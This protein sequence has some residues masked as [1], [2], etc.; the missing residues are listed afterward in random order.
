MPEYSTFYEFVQAN[1]FNKNGSFKKLINLTNVTQTKSMASKLL[2]V[3]PPYPESD[4]VEEEVLTTWR[5]IHKKANAT[6]YGCGKTDLL[7]LVEHTAK[8]Q[9][10]YNVISCLN[11]REIITDGM[12][13]YTDIFLE[14]L[15]KL[16]NSLFRSLRYRLAELFEKL[17]IRFN[18]LALLINTA[19]AFSNALLTTVLTLFG[20][21]LGSDAL[22]KFVIDPQNQQILANLTTWIVQNRSILYLVVIIGSIIWGFHAWGALKK[23]EKAAPI[24]QD[25]NEDLKA[26]DKITEIKEILA[27]DQEQILA[28]FATRQRPLLLLIDDVDVID[29][30]S[31]KSLA[32]L[33]QKAE[34]LEK[35]VVITLLGYNPWNPT[36]YYADRRTIH[37][38]FELSHIRE[39]GWD[40]L[41]LPIPTLS[42]VKTWLWGYYNHQSASDLLDVL[43]EDYVE[44]SENPSLALAFFIRLDK[45]RIQ[46]T[47][48]IQDITPSEVKLAFD[49]FL[50]RDRRITREVIQAIAKHE[51]GEGSIEM[52]KYILAYKKPKIRVEHIKA[53]MLKT[54]KYKDFATYESVLLSEELNLLQKSGT[55]PMYTFCQ[56]YMRSFLCTSWKHWRKNASRYYN[57][58]FLSI[59]R[60]FRRNRDDP[61]LALEAEPSRLAVDVLRRQGDYYFK[62]YGSSDAGYALRYYGLTRGG[63]LGKWLSLCTDALEN[64]DNL[65]EL[66]YWKGDARGLNP[67]RHWSHEADNPL[68]F[69][70]DIV[71]TAGKLYWLNGDWKTAEIIWKERWPYLFSELQQH[72]TSDSDLV[73]RV[74]NINI[75]IQS[76]LAEMLYEVGQPGH[77]EQAK[78]ICKG[79]QRNIVSESS[80]LL[81]PDLTLALIEYY[82][83]VGVGN[84]LPPYRF[85]RSDSHPINQLKGV[86]DATSVKN[87]NRLRALQVVFESL[88]QTLWSPIDP[89]PK[90]LEFAKI[91]PFKPDQ[92]VWEQF[93]QINLEQQNNLAELI[94]YRN[95]QRHN[96]LPSGRIQDGDLLFWEA[97]SWFN[98]A[99]YY[100]LEATQWFGKWPLLKTETTRKMTQ[101][102]RSYYAVANHLGDFCLQSLPNRKQPASFA[103]KMQELQKIFD[104]WPSK[105]DYEDNLRQKASSPLSDMFQKEKI[106]KL[107]QMQ[108]E[109]RI[110]V[111][112]LYFIGWSS[113]VDEAINR[114]KL[115]ESVYRQLG[116]QQGVASTWHTRALISYQFS[117]YAEENER[118][119]WLDEFDNYLR[120]NDGELGYH[121]ETF[122]AHLLIGQWAANHDLY[123]GV[124]SYLSADKWAP[125]ENLGLPQVLSGEI[126]FQIGEIIGNMDASPFSYDAALDVLEKAANNLGSVREQVKYVEHHYLVSKVISIHWWLAE[127]Y[128]RM[129][130]TEQD[131]VEKERLLEKVD[132]E[133][134][135]VFT[136][137]SS[138]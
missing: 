65:W 83:T 51:A 104:Q 38:V 22:L 57:E 97:T 132:K 133:I 76:T 117:R 68:V 126:N 64:G 96:R 137:T 88:W 33:Q 6:G 135:Y 48:N 123:L 91:E 11:N 39:Q 42:D 66:I 107:R 50:N 102:F 80:G 52:L 71:L 27:Q 8:E 1:R 55:P 121:L 129:A 46:N 90:Q 113:M 7:T 14:E 94:Q 4:R 100:C 35:Y 130:F 131:L 122:Q 30:D 74:N 5:D 86:I 116:Y 54:T 56:P 63:A 19:S 13:F 128:R 16:D 23:D 73:Q 85:L 24:W 49:R 28:R 103:T 118:P 58:V 82:Q 106:D 84:Y 3:H 93:T 89:L 124:Q 29:S 125:P 20:I 114:L 101:R 45:E 138:H 79:L 69:A 120:L 109:A 36:L 127:L 78:V 18:Q 10:K 62:Y 112:E 26:I 108:R 99:R 87:V 111:E 105:K 110:I 2:V 15:Y 21:L 119:E 61:D 17:K 9:N 32:K 53:I 134:E 37:Q 25:L 75:E 47:N 34:E 40:A 77:W 81:N 72:P 136:K 115:A 59:H 12:N 67:K 98:C 43:D 60:L 44:I 70:P 31:F 41:E 92:D 95:L